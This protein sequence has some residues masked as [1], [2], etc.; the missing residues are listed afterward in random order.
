MRLSAAIV[1]VIGSV[2][3]LVGSLSIVAVGGVAHAIGIA[4]AGSIMLNGAIALVLAVL[5][6]AGGFLAASRPTLA[7]VLMLVSAIGGGIALRTAYAAASVLL[8]AGGLL[9]MAGRS[10]QSRPAASDVRLAA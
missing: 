4:G 7:A 1:G 3:G 9:A 6:G 10:V 5:G 2:W 8:G